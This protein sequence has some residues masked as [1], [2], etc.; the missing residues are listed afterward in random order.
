[1]F[2]K[3]K[4]YLGISIFWLALSL[5]SD[6]INTLILPARISGIVDQSHQ[7]SALGLLTFLGLLAG[8]IVQPVAG[9]AS[10]RWRERIGRKGFLI[11]GA[12]LTLVFL[13]LFG[14]SGTLAFL[15]IVYL[16]IQVSSSLAQ[17]AQQAFIPDL[18]PASNR[19]KASGWKAFMDIGG[20]MLGFVLIGQLLGSGMM[21]AALVAIGLGLA[22][23]L[24]LTIL[25][26]QERQAPTSILAQKAVQKTGSRLRGA[27]QFDFKEH[28]PFA[29]LI[30]SRF[31]FLLGTYSVGRFLLYF[32]ASRLGSD[33][34]EAAG[35]VG[36]LLAGLALATVLAAPLAGWAA[37]RWARIPVILFGAIISAT[38]AILL[39]FSSSLGQIF[40]FGLL[41]SLGS[42]AF[43]S[44]N[45]ALT[46]DLVPAGESARFFGLAN[47]GT[48]GAAA[49]AGLF[50]PLVDW[51]NAIRP[52]AGFPAL[53]IAAAMAFLL[54]ALASGWI[55]RIEPLSQPDTV[56]VFD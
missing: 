23:A 41:M 48:A 33:P 35:Q 30:A 19:G 54:S 2:T 44:A 34:Q 3:I 49:A 8:M 20:A 12:G 14:Y 15:A 18:V 38:G 53:F 32:V 43:S 16:L 29:W 47:I 40:A 50:G 36:S 31:L 10:D 39:I 37:D 22:A 46:A 7:A 24:L 6:G 28:R 1:M 51:A 11:I 56:H 21:N 55:H 42:A 4:F 25:L 5:L 52:G 27:F 13:G 9:A 17:A 26:V 45:W